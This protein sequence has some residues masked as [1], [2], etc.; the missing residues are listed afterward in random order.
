M[1]ET[2]MLWQI[3]INPSNESP[4]LL[5]ISFPARDGMAATALD[6]GMG[7]LVLARGVLSAS[8]RALHLMHAFPGGM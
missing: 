2:C 5:L 8:S 1:R 3:A 4:P 7:F 6:I